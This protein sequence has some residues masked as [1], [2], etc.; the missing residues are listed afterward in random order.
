MVSG[1]LLLASIKQT[2]KDREEVKPMRVLEEIILI[3]QSQIDIVN[4]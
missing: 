2:H 4:K 3:I 1:I